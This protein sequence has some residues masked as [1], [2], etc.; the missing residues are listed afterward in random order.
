MMFRVK[1]NM[2]ILGDL[3]KA[4]TIIETPDGHRAVV[5]KGLDPGVDFVR[6]GHSMDDPHDVVS[7]D[8]GDVEGMEE[9]D[10]PQITTVEYLDI[11]K[12]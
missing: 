6:A 12:R 3:F 5:T 10:M 2:Y 7:F 9:G 8:F 1:A 4:G 11:T